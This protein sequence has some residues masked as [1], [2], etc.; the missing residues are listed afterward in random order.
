MRTRSRRLLGRTLEGLRA[1]PLRTFPR[2]TLVAGLVAGG[3]SGCS[4]LEPVARYEPITDP[5]Q[6]YTSLVLNHR[7]ITLSTVP[8]YDTFQLTATPLDASGA[9]VTELSAPTFTSSDTTNLWVTPTGQLQ[10]RG[11]ATGVTV[12][13]SLAASGNV[14][15][16]DTAMVNVNVTAD[17][18]PVLAKISIDPPDSAIRPLNITYGDELA[19]S[20]PPFDEYSWEW[21]L[22]AITEDAGGNAIPGLSI[23]YASLDPK[24]VPVPY[25]WEGT[26]RTYHPGPARLVARAM[27]YGMM[28]ADTVTYTVTWPIVQT[29]RIRADAGQASSS[30][31]SA[32]DV[33]LAPYGVVVW[34]NYLPD[35]VDVTFDDPTNV[36]LPP[37]VICSRLNLFTGIFGTGEHCG[38]GSFV[39]RESASKGSVPGGYEAYWTTQVRQFPVPG[40]YRYHSER[41]GFAGRIIVTNDP[42][43]TAL[44]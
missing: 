8:G 21:G 40:V 24:I 37:A 27:A 26:I 43:P 19:V 38:T 34:L 30:L 10:A 11:A 6:L 15:H 29:I 28:L 9:P 42:D 33:W 4:G 14:R 5:T 36:A 41:A 20:V 17:P 1:F 35:S 16:A 25:H 2:R 22:S 31:L 13:A 18:P 39:M 23:E 3:L 7:A 12:I 32:N 44:P